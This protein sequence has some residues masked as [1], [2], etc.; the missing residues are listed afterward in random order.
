MSRKYGIEVKRIRLDSSGEN[1][2]TQK[3]C[4]KQ[5]LGVI[6]EFTLPGTPQQNSVVERKIPTLM[7]RARAMLIQAGILV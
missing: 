6:F 7:G 1:R 2:S 5:S 4:G 3:E